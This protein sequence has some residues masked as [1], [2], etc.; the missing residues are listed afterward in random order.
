MYMYSMILIL[1]LTRKATNEN[2]YTFRAG[3]LENNKS[4]LKIDGSDVSDHNT[5]ISR[6]VLTNSSFK[7]NIAIEADT[8]VTC[9]VRSIS[10]D[11]IDYYSPNTNF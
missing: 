3:I 6:I 9:V 2:I 11:I 4:V 10:A 1:L 7:F 8:K 5:V